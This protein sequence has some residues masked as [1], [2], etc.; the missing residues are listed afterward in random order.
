MKNK[1]IYQK[2]CRLQSRFENIKRDFEMLIGEY[3]RSLEVQKKIE[4][5]RQEH[6]NNT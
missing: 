3:Q 1:E 4:A 6:E 2:M 5:E